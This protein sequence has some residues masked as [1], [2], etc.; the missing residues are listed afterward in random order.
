MDRGEQVHSDPQHDDHGLH[1]DEFPGSE[2]RRQPVSQLLAPG[3]L[4]VAALVSRMQVA[5]GTDVPSAVVAGE[6]RDACRYAV[7]Y[8][9]R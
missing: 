3:S 2:H 9:P 7:I 4:I 1:D 6:E 8:L 5:A